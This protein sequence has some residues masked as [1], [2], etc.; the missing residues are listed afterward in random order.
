M[1]S[2]DEEQRGEAERLCAQLLARACHQDDARMVAAMLECGLDPNHL[3][4]RQRDEDCEGEPPLQLTGLFVASLRGHAGNARPRLPLAHD[5]PAPLPP[6]DCVRV[7]LLARA[8]PKLDMGMSTGTVN[9]A[10][11]VAEQH[12]NKEIVELLR[13][14]RTRDLRAHTTAPALGH[15]PPAGT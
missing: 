1:A 2:G 8:D 12:E 9:T 6:P 5:H 3:V 10:L 15:A 4:A 11:D 13:E 7:L 14:A